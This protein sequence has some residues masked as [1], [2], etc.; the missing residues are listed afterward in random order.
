MPVVI[1]FFANRV[2]F[3][4]LCNLFLIVCVRIIVINFRPQLIGANC[5]NIKSLTLAVVI[6][7]NVMFVI[8]IMNGKLKA[9]HRQIKQLVCTKT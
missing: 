8:E 9:N 4:L 5:D 6:M 2:I 1:Y 3:K 7:L